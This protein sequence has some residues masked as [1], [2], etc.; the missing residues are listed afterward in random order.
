MATTATNITD[1]RKNLKKITDDVVDY[2][3]HIIITKPKNKNVVL[4]SEDEFRSWK[5]T[6]YILESNENRKAL[7]KSIDQLERGHV[8]TLSAEDWQR[9]THED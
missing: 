8:K 9:M 7:D 4:M 1:A 5:E 3:D 2:N 6:L